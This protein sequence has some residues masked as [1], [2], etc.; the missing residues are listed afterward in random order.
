MKDTNTSELCWMGVEQLAEGLH[1]RQ[2]SSLE[3]TQ[4]LLGR[5]EQRNPDFNAMISLDAET[6]L[7]KA[8]H[9]DA[10]RK[11]ATAATDPAG[12]LAGIP[13]VHKD[14]FCT[15]GFPTSCGSKMLD[16]WVPPYNATAVTRLNA[17]ICLG[18]ANMDEFAMGSSNET[19]WFGPVRNPWDSERVPGGSSGGSAAAVA[20]GFAP[21]A[22]GTD[23]G[24]SIRQPAA[25]CGVTGI[26]PTYGRV[27]RWGMI[28]FASSLD[29]AGIFARSALDAAI[30]LQLMAG[31][32]SKDSTCLNEPVPDWYGDLKALQAQEPSSQSLQGIRLGIPKQYIEHLD[33][34]GLAAFERATAQFQ[35]LG[36]EILP[37][38]LP[39]AALGLACYYILASAECS[40][41]LARYDG[42][43]YGYRT[44]EPDH[45]VQMYRRTRSEGF[46][47]EVKRRIMVG[48][49]VLSSG[50]YE[51]YYLQAQKCRRLVQQDFVQAFQQVD[52]LISPAALGPAF[53][54]GMH[55]QDPVEMYRQDILTLGANLAGL[56]AI[57][58]PG[59]LQQELPVGIQIVGKALDEGTILQI[60]HQFQR[61]TDW[62]LARPPFSN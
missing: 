6:A 50:Y 28:A 45:L 58:I 3:V 61:T 49:Y 32:D 27:S 44:P 23:T 17:A 62:H 35:S 20:A 54:L 24:G 56:P 9:A 46:G 29:Q 36:A 37:V 19:S 13:I 51:A 16:G 59:G 25:F 42:V 21:I 48:T 39:H 1:Q 7:K 60:A 10:Q 2:F 43:R 15:Q 38:D 11:G 18:K 26:K 41:N 12:L 8:E 57:A 22:T 52:A 14:I 30:A 47:K 55:G 53:Q 5:M 40:S 33:A 34:S 4:A 31:A